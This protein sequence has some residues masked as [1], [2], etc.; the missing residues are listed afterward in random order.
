MSFQERFSYVDSIPR[1]VIE[2]GFSPEIKKLLVDIEE[3]FSVTGKNVY[4]L[5]F[6]PML[7]S[8]VTFA[9]CQYYWDEE[10][11]MMYVYLTI[12]VGV[13]ITLLICIVLYLIQYY[14]WNYRSKQ[15]TEILDTFNAYSKPYGLYIT[16]NEDY[17]IYC[18]S[19]SV[20]K[21]TLKRINLSELQPQLLFKMDV[22]ARQK[23]CNDKGLDF[24]LP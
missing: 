5:A 13:S 10:D 1:N 11:G 22:A 4:P 24:E 7:T 2:L 6:L 3:L 20:S 12:T 17:Q 15:M 23:Y 18:Y 14:T 8:L 16:W 19:R 9:L 21:I